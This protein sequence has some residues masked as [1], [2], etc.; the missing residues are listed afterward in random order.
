MV[1]RG[2]GTRI[3][4]RLDHLGSSATGTLG[5]LRTTERLGT[6]FKTL[7]EMSSFNKGKSGSWENVKI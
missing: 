4:S 2:N 3:A 6:I 1:E 7:S 5:V